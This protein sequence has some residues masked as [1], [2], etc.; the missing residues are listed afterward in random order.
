MKNYIDILL[1]RDRL[2]LIIQ[3]VDPISIESQ[4]HI[5]N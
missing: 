1:Y 3:K 2:F 4:K 5:L